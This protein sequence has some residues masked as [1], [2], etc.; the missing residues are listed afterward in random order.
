MLINRKV[1]K[2]KS[3]CIG[4]S[5]SDNI[6]LMRIFTADVNEGKNRKRIEGRKEKSKAG[7]CKCI[8]KRQANPTWEKPN[9]ASSVQWRKAVN[10]A[11][12][13]FLMTMTF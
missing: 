3:T 10:G 2:N 11:T 7:K 1:L 9:K 8:W 13:L 12:F 4:L 6:I 5:E